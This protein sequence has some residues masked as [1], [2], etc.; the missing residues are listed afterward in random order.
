MAST[1]R[2]AWTPLGATVRGASHVRRD[3]P[4]QDALAWWPLAGPAAPL[5]LAVADGHG[6]PTYFR[7]AI[8]ASF[9]VS[10]ATTLLWQ[11]A[12]AHG[13]GADLRRLRRAGQE[14]L[15]RHLARAWREA[16]LADLAATPFS[17]VEL[18]RLRSRTGERAARRLETD[19]AVAYGSTV[20]AALLAPEYIFFLQL[21]DGDMLLVGEDGAVSRPPLAEDPN[22]F[23]NRTTS[24]CS[25]DA[26]QHVRIALLPR[27]APPPALLLLA[28]DGYANSF[29]DEAAFRGVGGDLLE[30]LR[31]E[32]AAA[33]Q[34]ALPD[35]LAA[36]SEAGSGDDISVALAWRTADRS[37]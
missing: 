19:P 17:D 15:P 1:V 31:S 16:V 37:P 22:L 30:T 8:G 24:L 32:G 14:Q 21:G 13:P 36:T 12:A 4:A 20:V 33:V 9:A 26:W 7:S 6:A 3:E 25:P 29:V 35:W 23:A 5:A 27:P 18:E 11:L 28:T 10:L 2:P 34:E